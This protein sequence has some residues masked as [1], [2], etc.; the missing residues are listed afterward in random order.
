MWTEAVLPD[1]RGKV[2]VVTGANSGLGLQTSRALAARGARVVM[3][4]RDPVRAD[5]AAR[6]ILAE[7][8]DAHLDV[9]ELDLADLDSVRA[10]PER[11]PQDIDA[12][13]VLV[14]NAGIMAIPRASTA[15]GHEMQLGTNHLGHFA[16]TAVLARRL[17]RKEGSRV[18]TVSSGMHW[19]GSLH[20]DDLM[21]HRAYG[22]WRAYNQ[23][24]LANLLFHHELAARLAERRHGTVA[25]AAH[26][27]L[28]ATHLQQ[29]GVDRDPT[30]F[31]RFVAGFLNRWFAQPA[32]WGAWPS[33]FAATDPG[34]VQG[35]FYGPMFEGWGWPRRT[36]P[37]PRS[38]NADLRARLWAESVRLTGLDPCP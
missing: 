12:I 25:V 8:P 30:L 26:P 28:S 9:V 6:A 22:K 16:L 14:N 11:L 38:R 2:V 34:V 7:H 19:L 20:L 27:G 29:V 3:A 13:D 18:V 37:S 5:V 24:K 31:N 4:C 32:R 36:L 10:F 21:L 17:F 1:Q 33:L 23:S 35:A 15:Q